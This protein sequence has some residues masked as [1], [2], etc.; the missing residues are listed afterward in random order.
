MLIV[1]PFWEKISLDR[2]TIWENLESVRNSIWYL[3][4]NKKYGAPQIVPP[5]G[6]EPTL[7]R[8]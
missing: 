2:N 8:F 7:Y 5:V 4:F 1:I 6:L 3:G